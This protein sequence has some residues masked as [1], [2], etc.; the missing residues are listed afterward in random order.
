MDFPKTD[1]QAI[2]SPNVARRPLILIADDFE[3][4]VEILS[5]LLDREGY[6]VVS[7]GDGKAALEIV[8]ERRPDVILLDLIMPELPGQ[9]VLAIVK[10]RHPQIA[11]IITTAAEQPKTIVECMR[12][13][14][15]DYLVKPIDPMR[16]VTAVRRAL[17]FIEQQHEIERLKRR[18]L[19]EELERPEAFAHIVASTPR[20]KSIFQYV[21]TVAVTSQP[22]LIV[23][24]TGVGKELMALAVHKA[25]GRDGEFVAVNVAG[26]DDHMFADTLFGH[27][28]GAFTG[29]DAARDGL[30]ERAEN[31]TLFLDEIGDLNEQS[32]I[33]LLRL[34]QES[35]FFQLGAD[36]PSRSSARIVMATH[37]HL[38]ELVAAETFRQDLYYRLK[39]HQVNIPPLREIKDDIPALL[40]HFLDQAAQEM[41][42]KRPTYPRELIALLKSYHFPGN[43]RE[44]RGMVYDAMVRHK[45][46]MLSMDVFKHAIEPKTLGTSGGGG[47][48]SSEDWVSRLEQL[49]TLKEAAESLVT[50]AMRRSEGN[51][52]VAAKLLGIS[53]PALCQRLKRSRK[54]A[55]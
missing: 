2:S 1:M 5:S 44:L 11:V 30:V 23:G 34:L 22:V 15:F 35:E 27:V 13:G 42:K 17:G 3:Q 32:Q 47:P 52:G 12:N 4:N 50:E 10:E 6:D 40:D 38:E 7:A 45:G 46:R 29:A 48:L 21:E 28:K 43:I 54:E 39:S 31:G 8:E 26:L 14:A 53:R 18:V 51:Q 25:S 9:E 16:T 20:T 55:T 24:E 33:K 36:A 37:R 41:S 49:P 19:H